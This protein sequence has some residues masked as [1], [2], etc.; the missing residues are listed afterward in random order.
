MTSSAVAAGTTTDAP[1]HEAVQGVVPESVTPVDDV[2]LGPASV[3]VDTMVGVVFPDSDTVTGW[4][5]SSCWGH[6]RSR[7]RSNPSVLRSRRPCADAFGAG[8]TRGM[9]VRTASWSSALTSCILLA[10]LI[11]GLPRS[12]TVRYRL[13]QS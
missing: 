12:A 7:A 10:D 13:L 5:A 2:R 6:H 3:L 1:E 9:E 4:E 11:A 8:A